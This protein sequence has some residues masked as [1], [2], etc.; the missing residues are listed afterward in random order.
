M[1]T[2]DCYCNS[3]AGMVGMDVMDHRGQLDPGDQQEIWD[4]LDIPV[5]RG[6]KEIQE[7][8]YKGQL[9]HKVHK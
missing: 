8:S 4:L 3:K 7:Y 5:L 6:K 9:A 2:L 1:V